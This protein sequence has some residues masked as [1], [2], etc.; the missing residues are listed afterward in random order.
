MTSI[1]H[2]SSAFTWIHIDEQQPVPV[3]QHY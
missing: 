2:Q 3:L 1:I